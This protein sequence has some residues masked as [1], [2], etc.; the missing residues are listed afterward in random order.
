MSNKERQALREL[1]QLI[2]RKESELE[3]WMQDMADPAFL[4]KRRITP[5]EAGE[6]MSVLENEIA[7]AY[8][9]WERLETL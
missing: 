6:K 8:Q 7:S 9:E 3:Q 4:A 2:E 1:P 5:A